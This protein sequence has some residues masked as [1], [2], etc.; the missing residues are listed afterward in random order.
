MGMRVSH[1]LLGLAF[2]AVPLPAFADPIT[3]IAGARAVFAD[4]GVAPIAPISSPVFN[5]PVLTTSASVSTPDG[6]A[7]SS[8]SLTSV[9]DPA[10]AQYSGTGSTA[11]SHASTNVASGGY[12]QTDY[13]VMFEVTAAQQFEFTGSFATAGVDEDHRSSWYAELLYNPYDPAV[14]TAFSF[15]GRDTRDLLTTGLLLPGV[16]KFNLGTSSGVFQPGTGATSTAF[17]FN[18]AF[19]DPAVAATPEPASMVLIGTGLLGLLARRRML[20]R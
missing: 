18:L 13:G 12:T 16:Y 8:A 4:A 14:T 2:W 6:V 1:V 10:I 20:K 9:I 7:T 5:L 17:N 15:S 19:A 11:V 3:L